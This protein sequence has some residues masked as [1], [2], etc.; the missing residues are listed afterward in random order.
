MVTNRK[1]VKSRLPVQCQNA[2]FQTLDQVRS[3]VS[4]TLE[5]LEQS[6]VQFGVVGS[7]TDVRSAGAE[8]EGEE[9][10]GETFQLDFEGC[11]AGG[12]HCGGDLKKKSIQRRR[13]LP[14]FGIVHLGNYKAILFSFACFYFIFFSNFQRFCFVLGYSRLTML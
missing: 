12:C 8:A 6:Q 9:V 7:T 2:K 13:A 3:E 4:N 5:A 14:K 1:T 10:S 11:L